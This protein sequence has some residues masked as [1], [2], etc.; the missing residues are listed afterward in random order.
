MDDCREITSEMML[1]AVSGALWRHIGPRKTYSYEDA[2]DAVG[3]ETRT[4]QSW[5]LG[6]TVP[7]CY[8][9]IRLCRWLGPDF[10]ND[11]V[12]LAGLMTLPVE[13]ADGCEFALNE[14]IVGLLFKLAWAFANDGKVDHQERAA[15]LPLARIAH[16]RIGAYLSDHD[17]NVK[18]LK[19][20]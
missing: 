1:T 19:A 6:E 12:G 16:A 14:D 11:A 2:A 9:L 8:R 4:M 10:A 3:V 20:G 5:V 18:P 17:P 7:S 15:I 13:A